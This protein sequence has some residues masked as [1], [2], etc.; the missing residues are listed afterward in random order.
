V[1]KQYKDVGRINWQPCRTN[2]FS[3]IYS[4][5]DVKLL[6]EMDARHVILGGLLIAKNS[7]EE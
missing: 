4:A 1:I 7:T 3:T 6:A 2:G 5:K